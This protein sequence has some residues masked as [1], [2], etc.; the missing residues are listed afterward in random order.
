MSRAL[1]LS[2]GAFRGAVQVPVIEELCSRNYYDAIYGVS[3]GSINGAMAA[4]DEL[5]KLREIWDTVDG[6]G[7][8]LRPKWYWPFKGYYDM[9]P[10]RTKLEKYLSLDRVKI[11]YRAGV[12][13]G[14]TGEYFNLKAEDMLLDREYHDAVQASSCQA[15]IMIPGT[16][17]H[18]GKE[19]LGYDGGYRNIIPVPDRRYDHI[20]VVACT[21][22]DRMK[23]RDE[24]KSKDLLP[25]LLRGIQIMQ[26]EIFDRDISSIIWSGADSVTVYAP[27]ESPG[28]S[29]VA[30]KK[31]IEFRYKLGEEALRWP[32]YLK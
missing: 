26:D 24:F 28:D 32:H 3:V 17:I 27:Q 15:G 5:D 23:M 1:L 21:P 2:G 22:I 7:S 16:F 29:F 12:V 20:D 4:Q 10:L 19:H 13:S 14:T 8:F 30:D 6:V 18:K 31:T 11:R 9:T 25:M